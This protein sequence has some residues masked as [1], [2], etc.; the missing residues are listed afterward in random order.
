[1]LHTGTPEAEATISHIFS[2]AVIAAKELQIP[3]I[4]VPNFNENAITGPSHLEVMAERFRA[5]CDQAGVITVGTENTLSAKDNKALLRMVNREN[6]RVYFDTENPAGF[7]FGESPELLKALEGMIC[8][9]HIKD[10]DEKRMSRT[11]LGRGHGRFAECAEVIMHSGY[12]GWIILENEFK[13]YG[14]D[15]DILLKEDI[16]TMKQAFSQKQ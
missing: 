4:Q 13:A 14:R 11:P 10:G 2:E 12:S 6:F 7:G 8:Q 15:N 3:V 5:L 1:M 9:I 16:R